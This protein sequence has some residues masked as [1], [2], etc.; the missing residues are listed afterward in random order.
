VSSDLWRLTS[1][2]LKIEGDETSVC[3]GWPRPV[4]LAV[5]GVVALVLIV[6]A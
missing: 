5:I 6:T 1:D 4:F 2:S 3:G